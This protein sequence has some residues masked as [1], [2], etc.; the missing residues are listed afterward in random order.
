MKLLRWII[1]PPVVVI[2]MALAVAN[3]APVTFSLD[4]FDPVSP[5]IGLEVPLFLVILV[6][7]LI[8]IL[9]GGAGAWA[10]ARRKAAKARMSSPAGENLPALRD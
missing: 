9:I 7:V 3:R 2:V 6:S 10:Q 4:P 5:A 8:G 1:L